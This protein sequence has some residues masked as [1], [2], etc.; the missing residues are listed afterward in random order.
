MPLIFAGLRQGLTAGLIGVVIAEYFLGNGGVGG[1]IITASGSGQTGEA[2]VGAF[3][4]SVAAVTL[5]SI[6]R[7]FERRVSRW[8]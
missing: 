3:A 7:L 2:F 1:L 4:F 5:T 6:L 8:R